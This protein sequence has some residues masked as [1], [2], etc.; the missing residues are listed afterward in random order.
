MRSRTL[1]LAALLVVSACGIGTSPIAAPAPTN[2]L[3][4]PSF[5]NGLTGWTAV[6]GTATAQAYGNPGAP[7]PAVSAAIGGGGN[8]LRDSSGGAVYEQIV[9]TGSIPTGTNVKA[10]G[11]FGGT[12]DSSTRMVVR[13]LGAGG[14]ELGRYEFEY[15]TERTRNLESVLLYREHVLAPPAG[16]TSVAARVQFISPCC[17]AIDGA[18]DVVALEL[19]NHPATPGPFALGAEL[20]VNGGF[21]LGWTAGSPL[22]LIDNQSWFGTEDVRV[23]V[24]P[25]SNS[26][27]SVPTTQVSCIIGG[28]APGGSCMPGGAGNLL[29]DTGAGGTVR[30][31]ID[32]RGNTPT[33]SPMGSVSLRVSAFVGGV[34]DDAT[35][36]HVD[37]RFLNS[38]FIVLPTSVLLGPVTYQQRNSQTVVL[39]EQQEVWVPPQTAYIEIDVAFTQA[40]CF[41]EDGLVDNVSAALVAPTPPAALALGSNVVVNPSF[42]NGSL[43]GSYL[44]LNALGGWRGSSNSASRVLS[45]GAPNTPSGSFSDDYALGG[46]VLGDLGFNAHVRQVVDLTGSTSVI[47]AQQLRMY[48]S[49]WLGGVGSSNDRAQMTIQF[50]DAADAQVGGTSGYRVFPA[51]TAMDRG[52]A[53]ILLQRTQDFAVPAGARK[54][55]VRIEF[56]NE[57]CSTADGLADRVEVIPYTT[58]GSGFPFCSG[59]GQGAACPCGNH[60]GLGAN[61][62]CR[63]SIG[64]GGRLRASG[65]TTI[66]GDSLVLSASQLP[67]S[68]ALFFQGTTQWQGGAGV[69]FGDGLRCANGSVVRLG[70]KFVA[71][72][73]AQYPQSGDQAVSVRGNVLVPGM[74]SY[75]VWYRNAAA[76]CTSSTFNLTNGWQVTWNF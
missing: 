35:T 36:A 26:D 71:G 45:Y 21:E 5:E 68:T 41:F 11:Y 34:L 55:L 37:V 33:F 30:Q 73:S 15:V 70:V 60:S 1:R 64:V 8:Y 56:I 65:S 27:A 13:F 40:C 9:S 51:V 74:R 12:D 52:N 7:P 63:N 39:R 49:C 18:A 50:V 46:L 62:G 58:T 3:V 59:D 76:F 24:K 4:N 14:S 25:Y 32:V 6:S 20:V 69:Q 47:D 57:C 38:N 29:S 44:Q 53:T 54:M 61:D 67:N 17:D 2:L 75:Q 28:G 72:G 48:A 42:E 43:P 16:T 66:V 19:V 23:E 10:S 22:S 31:R